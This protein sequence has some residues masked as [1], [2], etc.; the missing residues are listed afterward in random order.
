MGD[1]LY[2][3][4]RNVVDAGGNA[5]QRV[6]AEPHLVVA[7][8]VQRDRPFEVVFQCGG[9]GLAYWVK[10]RDENAEVQWLVGWLAH[11]ASD[12]PRKSSSAALT[13]SGRSCWTQ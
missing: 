11:V 3:K 4:L 8:P 2:E 13:S 5:A 7:E 12:S 6:L 10:R 9:G 1:P